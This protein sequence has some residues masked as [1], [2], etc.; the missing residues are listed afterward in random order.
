[1]GL[2]IND[3]LAQ[4]LLEARQM[5]EPDCVRLASERATDDD[6]AR[7]QALLDEHESLHMQ[8]KPV[9]E[10]GALFH[11]RLAEASHNRVAAS[12]MASILHIMKERGSRIDDI[13]NARRKEIDDHRAIFELLKRRKGK[14]AAEAMRQHI[15]EWS[16]T[17]FDQ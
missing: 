1:M 9:A 12:F 6:L 13:P 16:D 15:Q 10:Y 17:Y 3:T 2:L 7:I 14:Q 5:I 8:N 11:I 4:E